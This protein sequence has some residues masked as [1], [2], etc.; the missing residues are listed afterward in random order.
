MNEEDLDYNETQLVFES[1]LEK[2]YGNEILEILMSDGELEHYATHVNALELF[3]TNMHVASE[4][5]KEPLKLMPV[6]DVAAK[7]TQRKL[8]EKY[9]S[10][11]S[12]LSFKIHCHVRVSNLP[13]C[14]ELTRDRLPKCQDVGCFLAITGNIFY[15]FDF[16][17][18]T[19][20]VFCYYIL[21]LGFPVSLLVTLPMSVVL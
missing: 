5:L 1:F 12:K 14:P 17:V 18:R 2:H 11:Q 10:S 6:F 9:E 8:M 16:L 3:D 4:L 20:S 19:T 21:L 7:N 15:Y 13:L